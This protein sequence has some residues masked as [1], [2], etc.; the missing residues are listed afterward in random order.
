MQQ[1]SRALPSPKFD[2]TLP[3]RLKLRSKFKVHRVFRSLHV[4]LIVHYTGAGFQSIFDVKGRRMGIRV[5]ISRK[6]QSSDN[7]AQIL[8]VILRRLRDKDRIETE[9]LSDLDAGS[10]DGE[11]RRIDFRI[12]DNPGEGEQRIPKNISIGNSHQSTPQSA[13]A[14]T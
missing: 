6:G 13:T 9:P 2:P 5:V 14:S 8:H 3:R 7:S 11:R 10:P 4:P 1:R 12:G